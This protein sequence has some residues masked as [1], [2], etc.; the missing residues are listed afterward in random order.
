MG[1]DKNHI[2][3]FCGAKPSK[4]PMQ[5]INIIKSFTARKVFRS[6]P[7]LRKKELWSGEFWS[8][9]K[10]IGTLGQATSENVARKYN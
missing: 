8:D 7:K 9:D 6:V 2:H 5:I 10:Y 1:F 4:S 3:I